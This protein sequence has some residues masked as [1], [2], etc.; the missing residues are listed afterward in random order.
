MPPFL[1]FPAAFR[2]AEPKLSARKS[3]RAAHKVHVWVCGKYCGA[4][5]GFGSAAEADAFIADR[6]PLRPLG[7]LY[8]KQTIP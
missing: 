8:R 3:V 1:P 7:C 4:Y 5:D 6:A 2:E